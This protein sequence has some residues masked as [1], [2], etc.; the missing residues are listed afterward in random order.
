MEHG[1]G[2]GSQGWMVFLMVLVVAGCSTTPPV[3]YYTLDP[4][5]KIRAEH[6]PAVANSP[7]AIGVGPVTFPKMLDR[8]QIVTRKSPYQVD[9]SDYH[10]WAGSFPED[11]LRVLARNI[12]TLLPTD[13]VVAYPWADRFSPTCR[14]H[15]TVEQFDGRFGGDVVLNVAW[16]VRNTADTKKPTIKHTRITEPIAGETYDELV[17]AQ[18]RALDTLTSAIVDEIEKIFK[19]G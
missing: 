15:L 1:T 11:C 12:S 9:V 2:F 10:R 8:H 4:F 19:R 17:A 16:S 7:L 13:R 5:S 14:I 3:K 18:S 6:S